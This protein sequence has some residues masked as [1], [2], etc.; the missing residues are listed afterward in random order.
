MQNTI[1]ILRQFFV[2]EK[3]VPKSMAATLDEDVSLLETGMIDSLNLVKI[4]LFIEEEF[5]IKL[6]DEDLI[7]EN[8]ETLNAMQTFIG[9]KTL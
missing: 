9:K 5:Q 8:F 6:S 4:T 1:E 7:P 2:G 3:L